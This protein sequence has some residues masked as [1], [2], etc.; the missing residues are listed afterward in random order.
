MVTDYIILG[1]WNLCL[2]L[3]NKKD[4]VTHTLK[5]NN[6][7]ICCLQECEVPINLQEKTLTSKDYK[8]EFETNDFKKRVGI[9]IRNDVLDIDDIVNVSSLKYLI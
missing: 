6:I 9:Y 8:I 7:D 1:T 4:Y 3:P 5:S 2:G